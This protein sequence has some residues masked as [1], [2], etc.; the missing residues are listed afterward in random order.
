MGIKLQGVQKAIFTRSMVVEFWYSSYVNTFKTP[1]EEKDDSKQL[2]G[3]GFDS[4][5]SH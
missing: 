4:G 1:K 3:S 2:H 5:Q